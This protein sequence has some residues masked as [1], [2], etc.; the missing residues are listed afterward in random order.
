VLRDVSE[1]P[2]AG[3]GSILKPVGPHIQ[4]GFLPLAA[5][6][7]ILYRDP[8]DVPHESD[9]DAQPVRGIDLLHPKSTDIFMSAGLYLLI[10]LLSAAGPAPFFF[11]ER[12]AVTL[13]RASHLRLQR[14]STDRGSRATVRITASP[15]VRNAENSR[16]DSQ[17]PWLSATDAL[18]QPHFTLLAERWVFPSDPHNS[19]KRRAQSARA[20]P[21]D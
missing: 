1:D 11:P 21:R 2:V 12:P 20:P 17:P 18:V 13:N 7:R 9:G 10:L 6:L 15:R 3:G 4:R 8:S 14:R 19:P 16:I 5:F